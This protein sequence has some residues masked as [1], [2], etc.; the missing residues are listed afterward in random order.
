MSLRQKAIR[1]AMWSA[2]EKWGAQLASTA[3][4][5]L[6]ARLLGPETFGLV[7][8][9]NVFLAFMRIF[10]DQGFAQA[11]IQKDE[12]EPEH[13]D[14]AFW[15][16]VL[17][18][19]LFILMIFMGAGFVANFYDEPQLAP[20][21]R[22]MSFSFLFGGLSSVQ[23]AILKRNMQFKAFAARSLVA[24]VA[25]G[26]AGVG[27]AL[28]GLG[29]WSLV[30]KEFVFGLTGAILLWSVSNWKPGLRF[31]P[32]HFKE[33]FSFGINI[34][35]FNFLNFFNRRSDDILIGYFLGPVALG[36][37]SVAY[38]LLLIMTQVLTTVTTQVAL[39]TFSRI[40]KEREKMRNAYY[41]VT[42]LT[43]LISFPAFTLV[44]VLAP[45]IV[46]CFFGEQWIQSIA[47]MRV[48]A[49]I[50][51]LHSI[52]QF[53]G[54]V[55]LATGK[56]AIRLAIQCLNA[57]CNVLVFIIVVR[58]GIVAVALGYVVRGYI[59]FPLSLAAVK[60]T[61][62]IDIKRYLSQFRTPIVS[63]AFM[64]SIILASKHLI[65]EQIS[66]YLSLPL[67]AILGGLINLLFIYFLS[68]MLFKNIKEILKLSYNE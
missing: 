61:I 54:T 44:A 4:F 38:R 19:A 5:L 12:L 53:N 62:G 20:I 51:I 43:S 45:E 21:I 29:I 41:K 59:L 25:C 14:T 1:G 65:G 35:G 39:P 28:A 22:W 57:F 50:G 3:I 37:Y 27:A 36:Y 2:V 67:L 16:S 10:L 9:A 46:H 48:L 64:A 17:M 26:I 40:Q 15:T 18:G 23:S 11:I 60:N 34:I 66:P 55:L 24:T 6:L 68:P 13:L 42:G 32:S 58:W 47:V 56:P 52:S 31:S 30:I 33:L 63:I 49:L 8:L 7:A